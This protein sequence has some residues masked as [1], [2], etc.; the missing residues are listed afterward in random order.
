[1]D[2]S[3]NFRCTAL[4]ASI[5]IG[6]AGIDRVTGGYARF[7]VPRGHSRLPFVLPSLTIARRQG[8]SVEYIRDSISAGVF[9]PPTV[10]EYENEDHSITLNT[11]P[12]ELDRAW[13]YALIFTAEDGPGGL[14]GTEVLDLRWIGAV[15][16]DER[17]S[18]GERAE[19]MP[20]K[21]PPPPP[22]PGAAPPPEEL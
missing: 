10:A 3:K 16:F 4:G 15:L 11:G 20:T 18:A 22:P 17:S 21:P 13:H 1:M 14:V 6:A 9:S 12:I 19:A 5:A 7:R 2:E 8:D